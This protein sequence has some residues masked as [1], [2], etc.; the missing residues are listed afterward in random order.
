MSALSEAFKN[1][2]EAGNKKDDPTAQLWGIANEMLCHGFK[3]DSLKGEADD[4][5]TYFPMLIDIYQSKS[6]PK[7]FISVEAGKGVA[8]LP[9][10]DSDYNS[11]I[12]WQSKVNLS[13]PRVALNARAAGPAIRSSGFYLHSVTIK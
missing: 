3:H 5:G 2:I 1:A 12:L 4:E 7:K 8:D 13:E 9:V 10:K 6:N 11:V